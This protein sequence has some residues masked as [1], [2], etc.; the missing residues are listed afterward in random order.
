[1]Q[2]IFA[3]IMDDTIV[4]FTAEQEDGTSFSVKDL[5]CS[6]EVTLRFESLPSAPVQN[7]GDVPVVQIL[8]LLAGSPKQQDALV[9]ALIAYFMAYMQQL[10]GQKVVIT[11]EA[12]EPINLQRRN[13][14]SAPEGHLCKTDAPQDEQRIDLRNYDDVEST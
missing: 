12:P 13:L 2:E 7:P 9:A 1:V 14:L 6:V 4:V 11:T 5:I 10:Y 3:G 8:L